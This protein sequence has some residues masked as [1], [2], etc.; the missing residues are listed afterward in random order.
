[1]PMKSQSFTSWDPRLLMEPRMRLW[2]LPFTP[3]WHSSTIPAT[4]PKSGNYWGTK[5]KDGR[6]WL[7]LRH[8][9]LCIFLSSNLLK[10]LLNLCLVKS[11]ESNRAQGVFEQNPWGLFHPNRY[12][13]GNQVIT[14]AIRHVRKGELV[15]ENYGQAF[16]SKK[17][18]ERKA[19]L[20]D[21]YWFD[22]NCE[23]RTLCSLVRYL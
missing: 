5:A 12:F 7:W 22:C 8:S 10:L 11:T 4:L 23:V 15:P 6:R 18:S 16:P 2:E 9:F 14:K 19:E 20:A 17:K 3:L 1:M 13:S 21:R